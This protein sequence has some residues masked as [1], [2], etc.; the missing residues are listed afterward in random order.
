MLIST[1]FAV[2]NLLSLLLA[3]PVRDGVLDGGS[4]ALVHHG[5]PERDL[6]EA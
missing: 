4:G 5:I 2:T 6:Q 1:S 3:Q